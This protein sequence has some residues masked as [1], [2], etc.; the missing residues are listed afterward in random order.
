MYRLCMYPYIL[1]VIITLKMERGGGK[2]GMATFTNEGGRPF[3]AKHAPFS[4]KPLRL[5]LIPLAHFP[6]F[7]QSQYD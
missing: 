4:L 6:G 7:S 2:R 3:P 5:A 1:V